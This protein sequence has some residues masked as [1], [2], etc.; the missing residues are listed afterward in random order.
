MVG[1]KTVMVLLYKYMHELRIC[2]YVYKYMWGVGQDSFDPCT[3]NF[4]IYNV[5]ELGLPN[6][7]TLWR[8]N[9]LLG[10]DL[11]VNICRITLSK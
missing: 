4:K 7:L 9:Q 2:L 1:S 11:E 6:E 8:V 3:A 10:N 5:H